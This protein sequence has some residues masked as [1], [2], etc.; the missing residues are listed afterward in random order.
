MAQIQVKV[1][2]QMMR[3]LMQMQEQVEAQKSA[4]ELASEALQQIDV[5]PW[6]VYPLVHA[7]A[8]QHHQ[9]VC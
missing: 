5:E 1:T 9:I 6:P 4:L 2:A 8:D 3:G 7:H